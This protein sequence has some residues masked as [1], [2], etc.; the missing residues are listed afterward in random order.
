MVFFLC[1]FISVSQPFVGPIPFQEGV[2][3]GVVLDYC[4]R[5]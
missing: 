2:F 1:D 5:S 4:R 3:S